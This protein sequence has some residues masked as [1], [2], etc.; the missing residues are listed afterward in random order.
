MGCEFDAAYLQRGTADFRRASSA[1][2][3]AGFVTFDVLYCTQPLLPQF[4][5]EFHQSPATASLALSLTTAT[6]GIAML[7]AGTV[8][9]VLGRKQVMTVSMVL[10]ALLVILTALSPSFG[11]LLVLRAIQGVTLA[12]I[13]AVAMAYLTEEVRRDSLGMAMGLYIS[14]NTIG[15]MSGRL[16]TG[17][18]TSFANWRVAMVLIGVLSLIASVAFWRTLPASRHFH[19]RPAEPRYLAS[20]LVYNLRD[21]GLRHLFAMGALL[22]GSFVTL[23][24]Y[25][26]YRLM[27]APY[28]LSQFTTSLVFLAYFAG[29]F[30]SAWMGML[31]A[32]FGRR[33]VM[34]AG[35]LIMACGL[36]LT[37]FASLPVLIGGVILFTFGF[38]GSHSIA[39]S[40]VGSRAPGDSAQAAAL[41]LLFYYLGSSTCGFGGGIAWARFAWPGVAAFI[42]TMLLAGIVVAVRLAH[43]PS[44]Q[45]FVPEPAPLGAA[46]GR[47]TSAA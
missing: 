23:F 45:A 28:G 19:A 27:S 15:G 3:L 11:A 5:S 24:N 41:Y 31:S 14:G 38:F 35:V 8:S 25:L 33:P 39:S 20:Q 46:R 1:L 36:S 30:S 21:P 22:M 34:I 18:V 16:L 12:G 26:G 32:R 17:T 7:V 6:I 37:M 29:T 43:I 47:A 4:S 42:G 40:W 9:G 10:S 2:F 13:P 44:K